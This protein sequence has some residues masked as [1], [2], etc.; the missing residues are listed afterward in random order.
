M[1]GRRLEERRSHPEGNRSKLSLKEALQIDRIIP[2]GQ[3]PDAVFHSVEPNGPALGWRRCELGHWC[4][5][6]GNNDGLT[7]FHGAKRREA[8]EAREG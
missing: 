8:R 5:I 2:P 3:E 4:A 7:V 1:N 6:A